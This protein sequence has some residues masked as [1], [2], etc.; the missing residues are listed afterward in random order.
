MTNISNPQH[1]Q[2][3]SILGTILTVVNVVLTLQHSLV[4][5]TPQPPFQHLRNV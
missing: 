3:S 4:P 5:A 2:T 1:C